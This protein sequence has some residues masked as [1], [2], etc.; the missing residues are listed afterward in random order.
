VLKTLLDKLE[1]IRKELGSDKVFDVVGRLFEGVSLKAYME[2][3]VTEEGAAEA[4][5]RIEGTLTAEQ[6]AAIAARERALLGAGGDVRGRLPALREQLEY[7]TYRRLLPVYML[8]FLERA[9]PLVGI[10][11]EL[12][13][14]GCFS[15]RAREAGALDPLWPL[16][17]AYP[18]EQ[19]ERLT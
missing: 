3:A 9:A 4:E 17:E 2:Q 8:R 16:I 1:R 18:S 15:L 11:L 19:R 7:E 12:H 6:V 14:D 13:A 10:D 5:R